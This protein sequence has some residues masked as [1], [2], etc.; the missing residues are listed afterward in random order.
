MALSTLN[1]DVLLH[2]LTFLPLHDAVICG[3]VCKD[4]QEAARAV[5]IWRRALA[6]HYQIDPDRVIGGSPSRFR[7]LVKKLVDRVPGQLLPAMLPID[8]QLGP[9]SSALTG[10]VLGCSF[11]NHGNHV[12]VLSY[13]NAPDGCVYTNIKRPLMPNVSTLFWLDIW[14]VKRNCLCMATAGH[15][16]LSCHEVPYPASRY[17]HHVSYGSP[18]FSPDDTRL[19]VPVGMRTSDY[20]DDSLRD[21]DIGVAMFH[22]AHYPI[23]YLGTLIKTRSYHEGISHPRWLSDT[24]FMFVV[25]PEVDEHDPDFEVAMSVWTYDIGPQGVVPP[26][27]EYPAWRVA[28]HELYTFDFHVTGHYIVELASAPKPGIQVMEPN[29]LIFV[30]F[31][32]RVTDRTHLRMYIVTWG[33]PDG[34]W[35]DGA[36]VLDGG[37][38][39]VFPG[40]ARELL[41]LP[42][43]T[44]LFIV[45]D[46]PYLPS[47]D[48]DYVWTRTVS[49]LIISLDE[50]NRNVHRPTKYLSFVAGYTRGVRLRTISAANGFILLNSCVFGGRALIIDRRHRCVAASL[51]GCIGLLHPQGD[52]CVAFE[53]GSRPTDA[54]ILKIW[55]SNRLERLAKAASCYPTVHG[56]VFPT[57]L[58][59]QTDNC[60]LNRFLDKP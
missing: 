11:S 42:D 56:P 51:V 30:C 4:W 46:T 3:Q 39:D 1:H 19:L 50:A 59:W 58:P 26:E 48:P 12:A 16:I 49:T 31:H 38:I 41:I 57:A 60:L 37:I 9:A 35:R 23:T 27:I 13:R 2:I 53:N 17:A 44:T 43:P 28:D 54:G 21:D 32:G 40:I 45:V 6:T 34:A 47:E 55:C 8:L 18:L 20:P 14:T 25:D 52:L 29:G 5:L 7:S 22:C 15:F 33:H 36:T 24:L 10:K